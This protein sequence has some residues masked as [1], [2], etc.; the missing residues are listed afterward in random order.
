M[1]VSD[2][3]DPEALTR[4]GTSQSSIAPP[5]TIWKEISFVTVVCMA[6]FMTQAGLSLSIPPVYLIGSSFGTSVAGELSWYTAAYSLTVG[7]FILFSGR[8]GD[9]YGHRLMFIAGFAWFGLWSLL[10]GFSVW[11][12]QIFFDCCRAFQGIGPAMALPNA[13]AILGRT[14][15]PGTRKEMVFCLFGATAPSGF[16]VGG[17]FASLLAQNVWWP[18]AYWI[19]GIVCFI[20]AVLGILVIPR[21]PPPK[22]VDDHSSWVRLDLLGAI[23]GISALILLNFAWNQAALVD[24]T[25]PYTYILLIISFVLLAVFGLIERT[26]TCPLLPCSIFTGDLA[27]VLGC[28]AAGWSSFGIVVYYFFQFLEVIKGDSPL[29]AITKYVAAAP[30]GA[31]A[32]LVTSF[33]LGRV[34]PSV[35]MFCAMA[36]FTTGL[37]IFATVPVD[38]TYWAQTFVVSLI[39]SWGM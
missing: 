1:S 33:L 26:A 11:S 4:Q 5:N 31:V 16:V 13:L 28:I 2:E 24:W 25:N 39:L 32:A 36:F 6:Q 23:T 17:V 30:S 29:F 27:W 14:Y 8:L 3:D 20:V 35:I 22:F 19:M 7:T 10:A 38:Q 21:T 15:P 37:S 18:W 34:S 9:V 12:G